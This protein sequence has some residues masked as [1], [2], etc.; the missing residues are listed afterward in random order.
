MRHHRAEPLP[1]DDRTVLLLLE[2]IQTFEGRTL[3]YRALDVEQIGH[4]YEGLL[5][6][7]VSRV[8]D[9]TLELE[10]GAQ[11]KDARVTL[12]ELESALVPGAWLSAS[13]SMPPGGRGDL[14]TRLVD[15]ARTSS[16]RLALDTHGDE[17]RWEELFDNYP[18]GRPA[19]PE[20]VA[21]LMVFLASPRA[22]YITGTVV[23]RRSSMTRGLVR[24]TYAA[25]TSLRPARPC[26]APAAA[27]ARADWPT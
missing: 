3:S 18:G 25:T 4:V 5:E 11:A 1:I 26:P 19:T 17:G 24:P 9:V 15:L 14:L 27:A 2:A 20:E 7:T 8:E 13:G 22:G 12:G 16:A 10:A 23:S 6:R 21:D